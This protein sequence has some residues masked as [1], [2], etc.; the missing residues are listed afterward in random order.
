MANEITEKKPSWN[1]VLT[2]RLEGIGSALPKDFNKARFVQNALALLQEN[3]GLSKYKGD[4][5]LAGL[6]RGAVLGLDFMSKEAY[7]IPYG[8]DLQ[9]QLSY[10]GAKKLAKKYSIRPIKDIYAEVVKD[11]DDFSISIVDNKKIVNFNPQPFNDGTV[12]G[13][14]AVCEFEDGG[15]SV[16]AMSVKELENT[17]SKSKM[18]K[19]GAWNDFTSEMYKKV[20]IKRLMKQIEVDLENPTQ[21]IYWDDDE[22]VKTPKEE[23]ETIIEAEANTIDF[24]VEGEE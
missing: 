13:A 14:F 22:A 6:T 23:A 10:Q 12:K 15:I 11:G 24:E 4:Q 3:K 5:I 1:G 7:L 2:E 21:K 18:G 20:V 9:F 19:S 8:N 16:D 17:R